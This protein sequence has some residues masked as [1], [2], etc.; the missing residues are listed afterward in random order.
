MLL[1][2]I[3][4]TGIGIS[5]N[6]LKKLF[7]DFSQVQNTHETQ[8]KGSG[9]GLVISQKLAKLFDAKVSL[10]SEGEGKGTVAR[11]ELRYC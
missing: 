1:I 9:L 10:S 4:D 3:K 8:Q 5:P 7:D 6:N 11:V 2:E